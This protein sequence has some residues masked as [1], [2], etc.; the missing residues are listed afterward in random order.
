MSEEHYLTTLLGW[1]GW[2]VMNSRFESCEAQGTVGPLER[3]VKEFFWAKWREVEARGA[4]S[5]RVPRTWRTQA[6]AEQAHQCGRKD[7]HRS[8]ARHTSRTQIKRLAR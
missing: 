6:E 2:A 4:T 1:Q 3:R 5:D 8:S 7:G